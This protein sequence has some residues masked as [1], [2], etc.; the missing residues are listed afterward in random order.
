[1]KLRYIQIPRVSAIKIPKVPDIQN[2]EENVCYSDSDESVRYSDLTVATETFYII[3]LDFPIYNPSSH[4][5][6]SPEFAAKTHIL[7]F[8]NRQ[9]KKRSKRN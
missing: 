2:S 7:H 6:R 5:I 9:E 3:I 8:C 4:F 1:M